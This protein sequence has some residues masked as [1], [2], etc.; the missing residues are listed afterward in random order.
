MDVQTHL[1]YFTILNHRPA[2]RA[3]SVSATAGRMSVDAVAPD[4]AVSP[5]HVA[6]P[7]QTRDMWRNHPDQC[8]PAPARHQRCLKMNNII[9]TCQCLPCCNLKPVHAYKKYIY[10]DWYCI[11]SIEYKNWFTMHRVSV[12]C[13]CIDKT[14]CAT[15]NQVTSYLVNVDYTT[16]TSILHDT[17]TVL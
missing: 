10:M 7:A 9:C 8:H 16:C 14:I 11:C 4:D 3:A 6:S 15:K 13:V 12:R 2:I 1:R 5:L 17:V